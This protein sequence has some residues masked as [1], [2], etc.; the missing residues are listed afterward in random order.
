MS[1]RQLK[2]CI[3]ENSEPPDAGD[4]LCPSSPRIAILIPDD[5]S[6]LSSPHAASH[7]ALRFSLF[8]TELE[9]RHQN[10]IFIDDISDIVEK[11]TA[12]T[13]DPYVKYCTNEVYQQRTLQ[14]LLA[15]NPS[16]KE[17]LSRIESHEDCRNLPMISF[18]ILP[19]QRVTRLPLL[20]DT[21]C[22]KTPKDSS[23]YEVCKRA[24]KEVSKL[25]R[26]CNEGARKMERTEMMYTIN[27]QLEF[28][29][30]PFPLV[31][32]SRWLVKRGELTAYVEDTGLFSKRTSKQ[33]VYFFLFNDV[34]IITK[35]KSFKEPATN[36]LHARD[37]HEGDTAALSK[38]I[39]LAWL[40]GTDER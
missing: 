32:S 17:V 13:F 33:Q 3:C 24:L 28:K 18:L 6:H 34:L 31:S 12:S 40:R 21:I 9:E 23:K 37:S 8:F 4:V 2:V 15:T 25:V 27:S 10:N 22:Q 38:A 36:A 11:H 5:S 39:A 14:K 19:M 16:F 7:P 26:L 29:I 1:N 35:K 30:K 20:M